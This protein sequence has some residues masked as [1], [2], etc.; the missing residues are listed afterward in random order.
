MTVI[1]LF[2]T[3][4]VALLA[5]WLVESARADEAYVCEGGRIVDVKLGELE[6][7]KREDACIAQYYGLPAPGQPPATAARELKPT[8]SAGEAAAKPPQATASGLRVINSTESGRWFRP[9]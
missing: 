7:L 1:R 6:R 3:A 8:T 2:A 9:R 5:G 4:F